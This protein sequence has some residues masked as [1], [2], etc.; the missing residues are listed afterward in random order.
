MTGEILECIR[1][2]GLLIRFYSII[3]IIFPVYHTHMFFEESWSCFLILVN[4]YLEMERKIYCP[5]IIRK[6]IVATF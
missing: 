6:F 2:I 3:T 1:L 4:P 5:V